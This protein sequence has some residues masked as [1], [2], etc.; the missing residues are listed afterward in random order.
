MAD[1]G[2][3][4]VTVI[5]MTE[6]EIREAAEL[7]KL[8]VADYLAGLDNGTCLNLTLKKQQLQSEAAQQAM[9]GSTGAGLGGVAVLG[10]AGSLFGGGAAYGQNGY[11]RPPQPPVIHVQTPGGMHPSAHSQPSHPQGFGFGSPRPAQG[12]NLPQS[13]KPAAKPQAAKPAARPQAKKPG[14]G[15]TAL[16]QHAAA[17]KPGGKK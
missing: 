14:A 11:H 16:N 10:A 1:S 5:K 2:S 4:G 15:R 6:A 17:K 3:S 12:V 8:S 13:A 7:Y 9:F